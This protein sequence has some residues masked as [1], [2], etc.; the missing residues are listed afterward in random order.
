MNEISYIFEQ[1]YIE[2]KRGST[3]NRSL[4]SRTLFERNF[5]NLKH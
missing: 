3:A 4:L 2:L 5:F 1:N